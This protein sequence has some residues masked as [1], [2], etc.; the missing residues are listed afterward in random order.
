MFSS[1]GNPE[2][3]QVGQECRLMEVVPVAFL[4]PESPEQRC[5]LMAV[6]SAI[7]FS[8]YPRESAIALLPLVNPEQWSAGW[9]SVTLW[10]SSL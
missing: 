1:L 10:R 9:S 4:S 3:C 7:A 8:S 2:L 5:R 6:E